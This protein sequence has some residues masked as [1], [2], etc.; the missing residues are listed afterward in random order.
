L[1]NFGEQEKLILCRDTYIGKKKYIIKKDTSS[2]IVRMGVPTRVE[3]GDCDW[4]E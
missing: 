3:E 4:E 1:Y 2:V